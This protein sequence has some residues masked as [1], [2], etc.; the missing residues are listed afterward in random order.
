M[1]LMPP[2]ILTLPDWNLT[3]QLHTDVS[4]SVSLEREQS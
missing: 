4:K 1:A 3:F 2:P